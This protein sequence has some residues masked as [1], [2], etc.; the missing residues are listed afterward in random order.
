M[1][2]VTGY[3]QF[4]LSMYSMDDLSYFVVSEKLAL[5]CCQHH[6]LLILPHPILLIGWINLLVNKYYTS[7][8][9]SD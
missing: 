4:L 9:I 1:F 2:Y 5:L 7:I 3:L 8:H 6:L